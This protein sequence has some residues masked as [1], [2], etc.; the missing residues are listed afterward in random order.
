[1]EDEK[2]SVLDPPTLPQAGNGNGVPDDTIDIGLIS[3]KYVEVCMP[4]W[5]REEGGPRPYDTYTTYFDENTWTANIV[6]PGEQSQI[7]FFAYFYKGQ[8]PDGS[9]DVYYKVQDLAQNPPAYSQSIRVFIQGATAANYPSPT[10]PDFKSGIAKFGDIDQKNGIEISA[11]YESMTAKDTLE[12]CWQGVDMEGEPVPASQYS[13]S[14]PVCEG[15]TEVHGLIP[16]AYVLC[17]G[18][19]GKGTAYYHVTPGDGSR[20]GDSQQGSLKISFAGIG[21][22]DVNISQ[23][24]PIQIPGTSLQG[25]NRVRLFGTPGKLV[26]ASLADPSAARIFE[27]NASSY[28]LTLDERGMS[29]FGVVPNGVHSASLILSTLPDPLPLIFRDAQSDND[30]ALTYGYT[31]GAAADDALFALDKSYCSVYVK[32]DPAQ[33]KGTTAHVDVKVDGAAFVRGFGRK[34]AQNAPVPLREDGTASFQIVDAV[35][36][37]VNVSLSLQ[38]GMPPT[39]FQMTFDVFPS[40]KKKMQA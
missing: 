5:D 38:D 22:L 39:N 32:V 4:P 9:Y 14:V 34:Q 17:L 26:N 27:S 31:S 21:T 12:F 3:G 40:W 24:A 1:M 30:P 20:G 18:P 6:Q 23:G 7:S 13:F 15:D 28:S 16:E 2:D 11:K 35:A 10:F 19:S 8:I 25:M 37:T 33:T 29:S 36:E